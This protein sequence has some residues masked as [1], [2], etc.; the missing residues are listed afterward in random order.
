MRSDPSQSEEFRTPENWNSPLLDFHISVPKPGTKF[1]RSNS[2]SGNE[3]N[4]LMMATESGFSDQSLISGVDCREDARSFAMLDYDRDGWLD[5]ALVSVNAPR[6]R[7]FQN[8]FGKLG[9][10]GKVVEVLLQGGNQL[11]ETSSEQSNRDAIG[12]QLRVTTSLGQRLYRRSAGQGLSSQNAG[13]IR[14]TLSKGETFDS[15]EVLWPSG[16]KSR[17]NKIPNQSKITIAESDA[18][19]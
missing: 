3:R 14:V 11:S 8:Q 18:A 17:M 9:G 10:T 19:N 16:A 4:R 13:A 5:I 12:A 2:F 15:L 6:L 1:Y 7:L